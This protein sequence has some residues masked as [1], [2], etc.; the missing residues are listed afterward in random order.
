[1]K[2]EM[3]I[4]CEII[5]GNVEAEK[6]YDGKNFIVMKD[7]NPQT[8]GHSLVIPK[9]HCKDFLCLDKK[10]YAEFL[11]TV[12]FITPRI[13]EQVGATDFN[14]LVNDGKHAG[15]AVNHLHMHIIPRFE[16]DGF[17]F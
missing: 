17:K 6:D 11:E 4:F 14:L 5:S 8:T 13:L 9:K 2:K 3:C 7:A 12:K 16:G 15:Q 10:F 1:M